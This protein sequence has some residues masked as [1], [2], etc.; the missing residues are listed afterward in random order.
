MFAVVTIGG[1]QFKVS[2]GDEI[3]VN[4]LAKNEG[5]K[6][7]FDEVL[8]VERDGNTTV[9]SPVIASA[10]VAA[11]ILE[12]AKADKVIVFK[13]KRRKGYRKKNGHRQYISKI[14]VDAIT[15]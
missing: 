13:K 11:T 6:V 5:D 2:E 4:R 7:T 1:H 12:H 3:Y 15:A 8:L 9:G 10:S 14:K